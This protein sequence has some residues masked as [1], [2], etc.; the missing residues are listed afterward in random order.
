MKRILLLF[1]ISTFFFT[2]FVNAQIDNEK[3]IHPKF[4]VKS[5]PLGV[6]NI[7]TPLIQISA[8]NFLKSDMSLQYE[9][10][11]VSTD[12]SV[13]SNLFIID[14]RNGAFCRAEIRKYK[15]EFFLKKVI[16]IGVLEGKLIF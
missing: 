2:H 7:F 15:K 6:L 12:I 8:E 13:Y 3:K 10:G 4:I 5:P 11:F 1:T 9:F 16:F 14:D